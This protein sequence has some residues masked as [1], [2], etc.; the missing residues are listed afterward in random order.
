ML[1]TRLECSQCGR[2]APEDPQE[3]AKWRY[4]ELVLEEREIGDGLLLCPDCDAEDREGAFEE[5]EAG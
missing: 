4:G 1:G 5:G 2:E 3:L